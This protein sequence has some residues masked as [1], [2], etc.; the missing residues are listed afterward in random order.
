[1]S[2]ELSVVSYN[3][4]SGIGIDG[5]HS[6]QRVADVLARL[7]AD[8]ISLQE[9][10]LE[11]AEETSFEDQPAKLQSMLGY[12]GAYGPTVSLTEA[13]IEEIEE[14]LGGTD[15]DLAREFGNLILVDGNV[16]SFEYD[17]LSSPADGGQRGFVTAVVDCSGI[18]LRI[19]NT[20]L[21]LSREVRERQL[22]ELFDELGTVERP[23]V[24]AGD[25]NARPGWPAIDRLTERFVDAFAEDGNN[26]FTFPTPYVDRET[27]EYYHR[28]YTP[29][30]RIDYVFCTSE[31]SVDSTE[32]YHSLASDH[33]PIR[34]RFSVPDDR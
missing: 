4:H 12:D 5:R 29:H 15:S 11:L 19:V 27:Q 16:K 21:G 25:F 14:D 6:L 1:M 9:V 24:L 32:V 10:Q 34:A 26:R 31:M 22:D 8:I 30:R 17:T 2:I 7:D 28:T 3:I 18:E 33:S 20:H 13:D 23:T